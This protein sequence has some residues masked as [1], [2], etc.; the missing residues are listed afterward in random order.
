[1]GLGGIDPQSPGLA[2]YYQRHKAVT[3]QHPDRWGSP[4]CYA[5]LQVLHQALE[6][7]GRVDRPSL[8][9]EIANG[10][11]DTIIGTVK[12]Q[13]NVYYGNWLLGQW[14]NGEFLAIWPKNKAAAEPIVPK[15][16]WNK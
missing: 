12:L 8:I 16:A 13:D 14:Q 4:I 10:T 3:G 7:V 5:S 1:M 6:R 9:R 11:F 2:D 15:P